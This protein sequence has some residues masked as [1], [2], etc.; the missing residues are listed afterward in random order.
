MCALAKPDRALQSCDRGRKAQVQIRGSKFLRS[1]RYGI[2]EWGSLLFADAVARVDAQATST[3]PAYHS[4]TLLPL[5]G[6]NRSS[7]YLHVK[8]L[9][10]GLIFCVAFHQDADRPNHHLQGRQ[11]QSRGEPTVHSRATQTRLTSD[12]L[13]H[14]SHS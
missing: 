11:M 1:A 13:G 5:S 7:A 3:T 14:T 4:N 2:G 9:G 6:Q 10:S 12:L 8:I